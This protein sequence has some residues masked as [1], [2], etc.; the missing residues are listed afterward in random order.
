MRTDFFSTTDPAARTDV[1]DKDFNGKI[2]VFIKY[3]YSI[4]EDLDKDFIRDAGEGDQNG[5]NRLN[6][7]I[8]E[9]RSVF[10]VGQKQLLENN[11]NIQFFKQNGI[12]IRNDAAKTGRYTVDFTG[13]LIMFYLREPFRELHLCRIRK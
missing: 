6:L 7:D 10:N 13:G 8:Y 4:N 5:D 12:M 2:F 3:G 1:P 9:V 11:F